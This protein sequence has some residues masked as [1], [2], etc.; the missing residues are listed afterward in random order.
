MGFLTKLFTAYPYI[1]F[2]NKLSSQTLIN[3]CIN[4]NHYYSHLHLD[5]SWAIFLNCNTLKS[6]ELG[7][8]LDPFCLQL[9]SVSP[10]VHIVK[11]TPEMYSKLG[12]PE[13][14]QQIHKSIAKRQREFRAGRNAARAAIQMLSLSQDNGNSPLIL[15]GKSREPLFPLP[16]SGSISHTD[17][18]CLAGC[19]LKSDIASLGIDVERNVPLASHLFTSIYTGDEQNLIK[20]SSHIPDALIF[21]IKESLFKCCFPFVQVYFDFLEAQ[22][23]LLPESKNSGQFRFE[24]IGNNQTSLTAK[25]PD[26]PFHGYYC[27]N[28]QFI[29]SLCYFSS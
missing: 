13:E 5:L 19:A 7:N 8:I 4:D 24:L 17:G 21:S 23:T 14:E 12:F 1:Y 2:I 9:E 18:I 11:A 27:F 29:F 10:R 3:E 25:L 28:K 6:T 22:I 20:S 16:I 15:T 26:L